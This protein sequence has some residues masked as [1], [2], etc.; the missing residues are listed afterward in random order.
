MMN[1]VQASKSGDTLYLDKEDFEALK[2]AGCPHCGLQLIPREH[3]HHGG[4]FWGCPAHCRNSAGTLL[5]LSWVPPNKRKKA[6][7]HTHTHKGAG[8]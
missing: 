4:M 1:N 6:L 2:A 5:A 7:K 8:F 3:P